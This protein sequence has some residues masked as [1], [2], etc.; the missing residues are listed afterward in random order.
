MSIRR[1]VFLFNSAWELV[2]FVALFLLAAVQTEALLAASPRLPLWLLAAAA[3]QLLMPAALF[4]LFV[5][6]RRNAALLNLA[7]L[8]KGIGVF[9]EV[10]LL[11]SEPFGALGERAFRGLPAAAALLAVTFVDLIFLFFLLSYRGAE[12]CGGERESERLPEHR[13]AD[14]TNQSEER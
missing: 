4:F 9:V 3:G 12:P 10:I 11:V 6:P 14:I 5:D 8:G 1:I 7:R 2:R 13:E